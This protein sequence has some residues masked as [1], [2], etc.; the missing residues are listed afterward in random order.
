MLT[1]GLEAATR[2]LGDDQLGL[3][4]GRGHLAQI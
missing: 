2:S 1:W 3:L 4:M